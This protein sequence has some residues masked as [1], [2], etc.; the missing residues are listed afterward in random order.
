MNELEDMSISEL[1]MYQELI[2]SKIKEKRFRIF[3][4]SL[5][6][7]YK[8]LSDDSLVRLDFARQD[9]VGKKMASKVLEAN[10]LDIKNRFNRIKS[11]DF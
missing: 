7:K 5:I 1:C 11:G 2:E 9:S 6:G 10:Y 4:E 3:H 8:K